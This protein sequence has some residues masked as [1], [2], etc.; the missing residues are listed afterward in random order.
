MKPR[1]ICHMTTSLDGK[2]L[3]NRWRPN[4]VVPAGMFERAYA[5]V[6]VKSWLVGRTTG[7]EYAKREAY[8]QIDSPPLPRTTWI[9]DPGVKAYGVVLD[10]QGKIAW[11]C[12]QA[13]GDPIVVVLTESVSDAHLYGLRKDGVSYIFAGT[14]RIDLKR[15]L[16]VLNTELGINDLLL[17]GGGSTNGSFLDAGLIDEISLMISPAID[18]SDSS[19]SLFDSSENSVL[20]AA[21]LQRLELKEA[22]TLEKDWVWLRYEVHYD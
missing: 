22:N 6:G 14:N 2:I 17:Q 8:D 15:A 20:S 11:G 10:G 21:K 5:Q 13:D 1:I 7:M 16:E 19:A 9:A 18:G 3:L 12:S 4:D